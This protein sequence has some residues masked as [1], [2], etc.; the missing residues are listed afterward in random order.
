[1]R[2]RF[3]IGH[4]NITGTRRTMKCIYDADNIDKKLTTF[5]NTKL[6]NELAKVL[7][8]IANK[9]IVYK[10]KKNRKGKYHHTWQKNHFDKNMPD[11]VI[12]EI[13]NKTFNSIDIIYCDTA[14]EAE[15]MVQFL[16][17]NKIRLKV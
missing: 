13:N 5:D 1:M 2:E 10:I 4:I 7:C 17:E 11:F 6:N 16:N 15:D 8:D 9:D 14:Q 12:L 3:K